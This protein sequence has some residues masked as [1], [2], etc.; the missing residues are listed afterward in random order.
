LQLAV[1]LRTTAIFQLSAEEHLSGEFD[2]ILGFGNIHDAY[3]AFAV[4]TRHHHGGF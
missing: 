1:T 2:G 4:A 3:T